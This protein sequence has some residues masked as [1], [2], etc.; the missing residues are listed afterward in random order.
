MK[1]KIREIVLKEQRPVCFLDLRKFE[2][3]GEKYQM[4]DG[5]FRNKISA[6]KKAGVVEL[7]FRSKP[8]YYTIPGKKFSTSMT[9]DHMGAVINTVINDSLLRQTPIYKWHIYLSKQQGEIS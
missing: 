2:V 6:L 7:A 8:A 4:K 5:T 3:N 9:Q 1:L